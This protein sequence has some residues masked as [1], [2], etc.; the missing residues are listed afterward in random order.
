[1]KKTLQIGNGIALGSTLF[2]NYLSNTGAMNGET[3][4]SISDGLRSLFTPA[5]YAF[6]IWGLIYLLLLGF[7]IYQG[8]SLFKKDLNTDFVLTIGPWFIISCIANCAWILTWM[9]EFT[10][11]S[12]LAM[13]LLLFSLLKIVVKNDME[14]WDA[15]IPVIIFLWWPFVVYAGWITVASIANISAYLVKIQWSGWGISEVT[16]TLFLVG[17]ATAV[18]LIVTW[19]RNMREFALVGAWA[20]GA[21]AVAN[22]DSQEIIQWTCLIAAAILVGSALIHALKNYKTNPINKTNQYFKS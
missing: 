11:L 16:W 14:L 13:F 17:I 8:R 19:T 6:A 5:G 3:I 4:G 9:Y 12:I 21:I 22:W 7:A 10:G 18:N 20:L 1:M 15:P 2:M